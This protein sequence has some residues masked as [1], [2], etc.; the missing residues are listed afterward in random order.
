MSADNLIPLSEHERFEQM[1]ALLALGELPAE[2]FK[3]LQ[4]HLT[5]CASCQQ[6]HTDFCRIGSDD[7][8][9]AAAHRQ[10]DAPATA[11]P[12]VTKE[13]APYLARLYERIADS[14]EGECKD[15]V[16]VA[17]VGRWR[18]VLAFPA[19]PILAWAAAALVVLAL[20]GTGYR[21]YEEAVTQAR[22]AEAQSRSL[23][24]E[25]TRRRERDS[26]PDLAGTQELLATLTSSRD[27]L[28]KELAEANAKSAELQ[29][30]RADLTKQLSDLS[31]R[32]ELAASNLQQAQTASQ[33]EAEK[34]GETEQQLRVALQQMK[35]LRDQRT[36]AVLRASEQE[37][38]ILDL[39]SQLTTQSAA[40]ERTEAA[41]AG[42]G[43]EGR[44]LFGARNL[45]IVDVYDV[46]GKGNTKRTFGRV[47]YVEKKLLVFY[48]FDLEAKRR[49]QLA[50]GFQAWGYREVGSTKP[51]NL[52]MFHLDDSALNRWALS[53]NDPH[54]LEHID[55]V[56]VT[57]EPP[58]GSP[59][60]KGRRLLYA[61]LA[62]VPNHP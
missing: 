42:T 54:V 34:R 56:F 23:Q 29:A 21:R 62:G 31:A 55:A 25:L 37:K 16:T 14:D 48:A 17:S 47:Y 46:D 44:N 28:Q 11:P 9:F 61:S 24:D 52:G 13:A 2:E 10:T 15:R 20:G 38:Q 8:G 6:L 58:E 51:D 5:E 53:V 12:L 36:E 60:P 43:L 1:C 41:V 18:G 57:L 39:K 59:T 49:N 30:K 50:A 22:I 35:D 40:L 4:R 27:A 26:Q 19:E 45:H 33:A 3:E 7:L 32:A